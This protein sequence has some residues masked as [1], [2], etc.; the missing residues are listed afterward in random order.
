MRIDHYHKVIQ[1]APFAYA[2]HRI[3]LDEK[4]KPCDYIFLDVNPEFEKM[5]GLKASDLINNKA[6]EVFSDS[7]E[8]MPAPAGFYGKVA[9]D[10]KEKV[11]EQYSELQKKWYR[12]QVFSTE[13]G[14]FTTTFLDITEQQIL[15][16]ASEKIVQYDA[17]TI[18]YQ[19]IV[20]TMKQL[21]GADFVALNKFEKNTRDF[22]TIAVSGL[23]DQVRKASEALGF[24]IKGKKWSYDPV[25]EE[26]IRESKTTV[27]NSLHE[28]AGSV[29][30]ENFIQ[31]V[32]K[33]FRIGECVI[34]KTTK[35]EAFIGDFT[36]MFIKGHSLKNK[37]HVEA[38]ADMTGMLFHR[39]DAEEQ[40]KKLSMA[41]EQSP[42]SVIIT[43]P[44][45][46]IEY[47]NPGFTGLTG[48]SFDEAAGRNPRMLKS[49]KTDQDTYEHMWHTITSG[50][51]WHGKFLNKKKNGE[52]YWDKASISSIRNKKGEIT[53]FVAIQEDIT[54]QKKNEELIRRNL[55][56]KEVLL[57]E[58]HHRVKNNIAI[59]SSLL[60]LQ[61]EF[62]DQLKDPELLLKETQNRIKAMA[63]V[64]ELVYENEN[65]AE[66]S[67]GKLL[68]RMVT[69]LEEIFKQEKKDIGVEVEAEELLLDM[70][71]SVPL[72]LLANELITN[73][74]KHAFT[75][76]KNGSVRI[77]L[78]KKD[79]GFL[80]I[81]QDDGKGV[82]DSDKLD[83]PDSFG[84]TI[85][86]G[87]VR[88]L[89][90]R[91]SFHSP[92]NG[93]RVETWFPFQDTYPDKPLN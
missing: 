73:S 25:R 77:Y 36:L 58:I 63:M 35:D 65:F 5:T 17:D 70:N 46:T 10:G 48:Y 29:F 3:I 51:T 75:D 54:E 38:Y 16:S 67:I 7:R 33:S 37:N 57:K 27:F 9:L 18:D 72:S 83:K 87:L 6:S 52:L 31:L 55:R 20:D 8:V 40:N 79:E 88:Q 66:I 60:T 32:E 14:T 61:T 19:D 93:L 78:E 2:H 64:H 85:I 62:N 45:G 53:H 59:I 42:A 86:H 84:Y 89:Q 43:D 24:R 50:K 80:F 68:R 69:Y 13:K 23:P 56:E 76:R 92:G 4:E 34:V 26:K 22:T 41:V 39:L 71:T 49:G 21:S 15:F 30:S 91:I 11:F 44:D 12:V 81:V 90:G 74:Y 1:S 28:L 82:R 47:V